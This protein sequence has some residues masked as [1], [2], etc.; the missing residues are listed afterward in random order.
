MSP[1]DPPPP[2][3]SRW[4]TFIILFS[5]SLA[6]VGAV[7]WLASLPN[8]FATTADRFTAVDK[9]H[10]SPGGRHQVRVR[11][12]DQGALG[13][14]SISVYCVDDQANVQLLWN[15]GPAVAIP[16]SHSVRWMSDT[17]FEVSYTDPRKGHV[18][19]EL[20]ID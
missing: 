12:T 15:E 13:Y 6:I 19:K 16:D 20:R 2:A 4:R 9:L 8:P 1:V 7:W 11:I 3:A 18:V 10:V 5:V 14:G 17:Q